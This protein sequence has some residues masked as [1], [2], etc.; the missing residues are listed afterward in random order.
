MAIR[1]L[2]L[3]LTFSAFSPTPSA[4]AQTPL[5]EGLEAEKEGNY[6]EAL[7][8]WLGA[9]A[10]A[11][12]P[13]LAVG[14]NYIRL[15]TEQ[16]LKSYYEAASA[17]YIWGISGEDTPYRKESLAREIEMLEPLL[18][19]QRRGEWTRMLEENEPALLE[20]MRRWWKAVDPT[21][22]TPYN[23]R[24]VEHWERIAYAREHFTEGD[25]TVYGTDD[26]GV[27]YVRYGEPERKFTDT[28]NI[29]GDDVYNLTIQLLT[30]WK[31]NTTQVPESWRTFAR[32]M[33]NAA[34]QLFFP[35]PRFEV[36][37][38]ESQ[39]LDTEENLLKFFGEVQGGP[40]R[41]VTA[42]DE[43]IPLSGFTLTSRYAYQGVE[44]GVDFSINPAMLLQEL[45][46]RE[47]ASMDPVLSTHY[48]RLNSRLFRAGD[49]P[50]K[51]YAQIARQ[52]HTHDAEVRLNEAPEESS[53]ITK[54]LGNI[55]LEIHQYRLLNEGNRPVFATF[56]NSRPQQ[57]F[58][59]DLA[60]N[61][62]SM[63]AGLSDSAQV[64]TLVNSY[65]LHHGVQ[66]LS[67][68][69]EVLT[70][71][72]YQPTLRIDGSDMQVASGSAFMIPFAG[73]GAGQVFFAELHNRH[74]D[75]E[76]RVETPFPDHLRGM[77][78]E[79][80]PQPEP[81]DTDPSELQMGDLI[82]G[83]GKTDSASA[84]SLFPFVISVNRHIPAG[85]P[86]ALHVEVYHLREG[87][88]ALRDFSLE[89]EIRPVN[90]LGWT[91]ERQ[92]QFSL[93][94]NFRQN[95]PRF[96]EDLEIEAADLQPGRYVL[97]LRAIDR[98]SGQEVSREVEFE[99]TEPAEGN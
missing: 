23:E 37:I 2:A 96:T 89:Y 61:Q 56:M 70:D 71:T 8:I 98:V 85:E 40:F 88:D 78:R 25:R 57:R 30:A 63:F 93:T 39:Y 66:I 86:L 36:W 48:S 26:R 43:L 33:Q 81:L 10:K 60:A 4:V 1:F 18:G 73:E 53:T 95:E 69:G 54:E 5:Q 58:L 91:R 28:F 55:P 14:R 76:P 51:E 13:S 42:L 11:D 35:P 62:D 15:S 94:L 19:D 79:E 20:E 52:R 67:A 34:G 84:G 44:G 38:Y 72:R 16:G 22:D 68:E 74:P 6:E 50:G 24:L 31:P 27:T 59:E 12:R 9:K 75:S 92:D 49:P 90:F 7:E 46:Y 65:Q 80:V 17:M 99:V 32:A 41:E 83:Y 77:G 97:R 64:R 87:E 82:L 29:S 45:M 21:P 47:V 3:L